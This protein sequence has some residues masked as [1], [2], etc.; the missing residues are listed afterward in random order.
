[1][2]PL[3]I[4]VADDDSYIREALRIKLTHLGHAVCSAVNGSEAL[5]VLASSGFDVAVVDILMPEKDGFEVMG[6]LRR[7]WPNVQIVAISGGG[8]IGAG[9][10][11]D[12]ALGLG[13]HAVLAKPFSFSELAEVI[14]S[15]A[16]PEQSLI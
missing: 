5:Q 14:R 15:L 11:L 7:R 9:S 2:S 12:S 4:L 16:G 1:M 8:R 6:E 10:L 3:K 13:A